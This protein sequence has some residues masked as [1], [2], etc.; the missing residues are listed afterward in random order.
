MLPTRTDTPIM[1]T[2]EQLESLRRGLTRARTR[3]GDLV[4]KLSSC[5][6]EILSLLSQ[7]KDT[8]KIA[9]ALGI[10]ESTVNHHLK[11]ILEKLH[12]EN[13][14]QATLFAICNCMGK[15]QI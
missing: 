1:L 3:R 7:G 2:G 6:R 9:L 8:K 11:S 5:E 13:G 10:R 14:V 4:A 12:L 15:H